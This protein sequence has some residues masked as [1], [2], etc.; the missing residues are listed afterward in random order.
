MKALAFACIA[1]VSIPLAA[2]N[3]TPNNEDTTKPTKPAVVVLEGTATTARILDPDSKI[4]FSGYVMRVADFAAMVSAN[5]EAVQHL[6]S[7][8]KHNHEI[9]PPVPPSTSDRSN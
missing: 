1:M 6:R 7:L 8:E 2:Q 5:N 3:A 4:V 9:A